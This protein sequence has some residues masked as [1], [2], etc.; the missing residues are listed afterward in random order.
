MLFAGADFS[1]DNLV[2]RC[3]EHSL[4][5]IDTQ[6]HCQRFTG[7]YF[8]YTSDVIRLSSFKSVTTCVL[9]RSASPL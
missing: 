6:L 9:M 2:L 1:G 5:E 4:F 7:V 3:D 8:T